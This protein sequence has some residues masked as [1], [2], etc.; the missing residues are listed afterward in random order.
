MKG[1]CF[2]PFSVKE[3]IRKNLSRRLMKLLLSKLDTGERK[4]MRNVESGAA[5]DV[6]VLDMFLVRQ[7]R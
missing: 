1:F 5:S 2:I 4:F 7:I 3:E 6:C